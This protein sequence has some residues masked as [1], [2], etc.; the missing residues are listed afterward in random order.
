M[1]SFLSAQFS[2]QVESMVLFR[3][4]NSPRVPTLRTTMFLKASN[5]RDRTVSPL[6]WEYTHSAEIVASSS[7]NGWS[8]ISFNLCGVGDLIV[9]AQ[10]LGSGGNGF[11]PTRL[12][13]RVILGEGRLFYKIFPD[14]TNE[15]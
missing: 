7:R 2:C 8:K 12:S 3:N 6:A 5:E 11:K 1:L 10:D 4:E 9:G 15:C 13:R 14:P